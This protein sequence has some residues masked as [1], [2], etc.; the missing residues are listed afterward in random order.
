MKQTGELL[1]VVE[2]KLEEI[3]ERDPRVQLLMTIPGVGRKT[4][5]MIAAYLD[6]PHR[7]KSGREVSAY[8][9]FVPRR[10]QSG[11]MDL[12]GRPG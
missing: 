5:E 9:G 4:A 10:F 1:Q 7:F 3:A 6:D 2:Q 12:H 11:E 8:A